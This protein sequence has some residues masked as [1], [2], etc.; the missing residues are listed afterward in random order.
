[1]SCIKYK[2]Y[3]L[4]M[5]LKGITAIKHGTK[6]SSNDCNQVLG[7]KRVMEEKRLFHI[8]KQSQ[9]LVIVGRFAPFFF[10]F[11]FVLHVVSKFRSLQLVSCSL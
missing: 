2:R 8:V 4:L 10:F 7:E 9:D 11:L 5:K 3:S 1:M 6:Q